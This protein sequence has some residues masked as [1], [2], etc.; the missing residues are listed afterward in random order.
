MMKVSI[1]VAAGL[2]NSIGKDND[3][4]WHLPTDMKFFKERTTGHHI[5]TG[6]KNYISIPEKYRPL[7]NRT[8]I[9][10]TRDPNLK[11]EGCLVTNSIKEGV[12]LA[13][14][15]GETELFIIGGGEIYRQALAENLVTHIFLTRV[16]ANFEADTFFPELNPDEWRNTSEIYCQQDIKNP[17]ACT[18]TE[19]VKRK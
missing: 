19:L 16:H 1:I 7:A 8:N 3:L 13:R 14:N 10:V 2:N 15:N 12:E 6:R 5:L 9:V 11:I 17:Y 4:L 18:F